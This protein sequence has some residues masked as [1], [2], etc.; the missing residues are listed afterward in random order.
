MRYWLLKDPT[1]NETGGLV[2]AGTMV[3]KPDDWVPPHRTVAGASAGGG[4]LK[5]EVRAVECDETGKPLEEPVDPTAPQ[6]EAA[7]P[8]AP[9]QDQGPG[10][11]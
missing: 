3:A 1:T 11:G 9:P 7:A 8:P 10:V 4:Q 2:P 6:P 5:D